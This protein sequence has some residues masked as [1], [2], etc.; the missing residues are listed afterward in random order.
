MATVKFTYALERI[1]PGIKET[2]A[3]GNTLREVLKEVEAK[4]P[5]IQS[6]LMDDQGK[7]RDHV[8]IFI[9]GNLISDRTG[10]SDPF[11]PNSEIYIIQAL[12]GG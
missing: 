8:N 7:L 11:S 1:F 2:P 10:L 3:S 4:Y 9:D 5:R 6:Y 12:S